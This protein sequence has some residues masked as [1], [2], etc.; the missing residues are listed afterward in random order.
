MKKILYRVAGILVSL[1]LLA[2]C[3]SGGAES[4]SQAGSAPASGSQA[5]ASET[6]AD[7]FRAVVVLNNNLGDKT[8]SDLA[9][10]GAQKAEQE[11]GIEIKVIELLGDATKQVPTLTEL[12]E[13]GEWDVIVAGLFNLREAVEQVAREYPE[14]KFISY[15]TELTFADGGLENCY[16]VM[17]RQNEAAF[18]GGAVAAKFTQS[19]SVGFVGGGENTA[20]NDFL[21]GYI[22]GATYAVPDTKVLVSYVGNFTDSAKAK[23]LTL[24][25]Y[26]QGADVVFGVASGAGMGVLDAAKESGSYA[27]GVD[28]DQA[29]LKKDSGDE[30]T[31]NQ[32][33]TSVVKNMDIIVFD[34]LKSAKDGTLAWGT[35]QYVGLADNSM[36]LADNDVYQKTVPEDVR[37]YAA[38]LRD[39]IISGEIKVETAIGMG[40][41]EV[42]A[43][44]DKVKP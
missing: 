31:A 27:I 26:Q 25:Q 28:Q 37:K 21:V 39:K 35:H 38:E 12:S 14:Q 3:A 15:D 4:S 8:I 30:A 1:S 24:A 23:E 13:S 17:A 11:L 18:L 42:K 16:S 22:Q 40:T 10:A 43:I 36:G 2:G 33:I 34:A 44:R 9:W 19:G 32:I 41:E 5:S 7:P 20:V 6:S 29:A